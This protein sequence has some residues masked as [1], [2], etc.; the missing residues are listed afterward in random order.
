MFLL[1][2]SGILTWE[3]GVRLA[4]ASP[5]RKCRET[6]RLTEA[7]LI[8]KDTPSTV[9]DHPLP[10]SCVASHCRHDSGT[11]SEHLRWHPADGHRFGYVAS[12]DELIVGR[13]VSR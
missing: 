1:G 3:V 2:V 12:R 11:L 8:N 5:R 9:A 10:L 7:D 6:L 13:R 4:A